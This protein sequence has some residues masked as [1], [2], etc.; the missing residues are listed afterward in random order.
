MKLTRTLICGAAL[1]ALA[2]GQ[3]KEKPPAGGAPKPF[4]VP[5]RQ[6]FTLKNGMKVSLVEYGSM[7][8]AALSARVAFG[9]ANEG[10]AETWLSDLAWA[11]VKEGAGGRNGIQLAE[12]AARLGGQLSAGAGVDG[13]Q[14]SIQV[15]S[16]FA[17]DAVRLLAD[18]LRRP[19]FPASEL[20]RL[21]ADLLRRLTVEL[22]QP[23]P[24]ADQAFA[25]ALYGEHPYGRM[26]PTEAM[27]TGYTLEQAKRYFLANAGARR[28][29][30]YVVG[31][32]PATI[33]QAI[34]QAFEDWAPGPEVMRNPPRAA[35]RRQFVLVDRP[36][37]EQST[38]RIGL[39][40]AA[41]PV[42]ADHIPLVV[43]D[44]LLGG[45]FGS[46]ITANIREQKGYTYSP[47]SELAV[48]Y[49]SAHWAQN[50]DV[51]T[52]VTADSIREIFAEIGRLRKEPPPEEELAGIR[53]YTAGLFVLRNSSPRGI[54][55]QF[56]F[57]DTQG[58]PENYLNTYVEKVNAVTRGDV[59]RLAETYLDP[60]KMAI[61]VVGD[62]AAV[63][64]SLQ[65][66]RK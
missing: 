57:M 36:G 52:K 55:G 28:T 24:L 3:G 41:H 39:P 63:E 48:R 37:S 34:T 51:T 64:E 5:A 54:L 7:P 14:A 40:V 66:Y 19:A 21:R 65:P 29:H 61:V 38:L 9:N 46:R 10:A 60:G 16:E 43:A 4:A 59:Q 26:Y 42:H 53:A 62:K 23:G 17:P 13:S 47:Y 32:F 45:A 8:V 11:L 58:L 1:A 25:K 22:A 12:E 33:R 15:L 6:T 35:A 56:A 20:D 27:L 49:R 31:R 50:A 44:N 30:L 18:V 2:L